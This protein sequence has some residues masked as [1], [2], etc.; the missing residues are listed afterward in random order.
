MDSRRIVVITGGHSYL[1]QKF[2]SHLIKSEDIQIKAVITPWA[3]EEG[4]VR[5]PERLRYL[6]A[7]LTGAASYE[8]REALKAADRIFHLAWL[9]GPNLSRVLEANQ[10]MIDN[11]KDY[12]SEPESFCF[13]S[14]VAA[15]P[16]TLSTYGKAKFQIAQR[17]IAAGGTVLVTGLIVDDEPRGPYKLLVDVVKSMPLAVRAAPGRIMVYPLKCEDLVAGLTHFVRSD[18]PAGSYRLFPSTPVDFNELIASI[19]KQFP[20][21]RIKVRFS[22]AL[23]MA[24]IKALRG[25]RLPPAQLHEKL[26][27][28]LYK[29]E[30][31]LRKHM[32]I[33]DFREL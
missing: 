11:L 15:S 25:L 13:I 28:F 9:R 10:K 5:E 6:K 33:E 22:Y 26:L 19:E 14:S 27:T 4:L 23:V 7:D 3:H 24:S 2:I 21:K 16:E 31:Y 18:A 8:L 20:R 1:G 30:N 32:K 12:V 17:V 29:D